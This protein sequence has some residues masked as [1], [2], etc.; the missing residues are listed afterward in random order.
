[1]DFIVFVKIV[2]TK[3]SEEDDELCQEKTKDTARN[4]ARS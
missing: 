4:A 2:E 3:R 1:M